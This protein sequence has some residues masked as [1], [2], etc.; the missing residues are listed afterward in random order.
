MNRVY[1]KEPNYEVVHN[2][3]RYIRLSTD[4]LDWLKLH[5]GANQGFDV[6]GDLRGAWGWDYIGS[7]PAV[8]VRVTIQ[9]PNKAMMF[10]LAWGN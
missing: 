5:V 8:V 1:L 3:N 7:F 9:D 2:I 10:K 6:D 4:V